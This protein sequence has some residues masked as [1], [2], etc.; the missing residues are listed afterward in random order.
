MESLILRRSEFKA[1]NAADLL[2]HTGFLPL[3]D[4]ELHINQPKLSNWDAR[5]NTPTLTHSP[6]TLSTPTPTAPIC[7]LLVNPM[8]S[9]LDAE[10][11]DATHFRSHILLLTDNY[12][13]FRLICTLRGAHLSEADFKPILIVCRYAPT[14]KDYG[15]LS[16]FPNLWWM[17][18]DPRKRKVL[19]AAGLEGADR[20]SLLLLCGLCNRIRLLLVTLTVTLRRSLFST[21]IRMCAGQMMLTST[22]R[23][24]VRC[25]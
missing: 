14:D 6:H 21:C 10:L 9:R 1:T 7:R 12:R 8:E 3:G 5:G 19:R 2:E 22:S 18:G 17:V 4:G 23:T 16:P 25:K 11:K 24:V 20:V 13:L 15:F